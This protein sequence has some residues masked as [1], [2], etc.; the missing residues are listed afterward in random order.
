VRRV[1]FDKVSVHRTPEESPGYLL[2]RVSTR[3][4]RSIEE[5]LK[6]LK[7]THPQF[8]V[9]AVT[10]WLTRTGEKASQAEIARHAGLDPN[11]TSQVLRG[12]QAKGPVERPR[13]IDER[14][15]YPVLTEKGSRLLEKALPAVEGAD[16]KFFAVLDL[17]KTGLLSALQKLT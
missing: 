17:K 13:S 15:K 4:R 12:L 16:A 9:L 1:D 8:V 3:W 7:L 5:V 2:W 6:P 11:T 14:S 10:S